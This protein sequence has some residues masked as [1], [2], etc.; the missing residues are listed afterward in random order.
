MEENK[1]PNGRNS[2]YII[3]KIPVQVEMVSTRQK[4]SFHWQKKV[5]FQKLDFP[6]GFH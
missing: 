3:D 2:Y 6:Y 5:I 1:T 4:M